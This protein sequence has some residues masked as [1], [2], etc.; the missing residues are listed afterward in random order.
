MLHSPC[1]SMKRIFEVQASIRGTA[2]QTSRPAHKDSLCLAF[3]PKRL[4]RMVQ[5]FTSEAE[6]KTPSIP[7]PAASF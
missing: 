5:L 2:I 6:G 1:H 4:W 7:I 3:D